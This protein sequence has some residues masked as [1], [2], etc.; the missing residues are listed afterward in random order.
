M[1]K[2]TYIALTIGPIYRT[3]ESA[4]RTRM[5]WG[6]SYMFS[7][8]IRELV[9]ELANNEGISSESF[10][11]PNTD[12]LNLSHAENSK[13]NGA[14]IFPDRFIFQSKE[15]DLLRVSH[16]IDK[17]FKKIARLI[18]K[19]LINAP[20]FGV[21]YKS[22]SNTL[23]NEVFDQL[24]G[25]LQIY[26]LEQEVKEGD[27]IPKNLY[28]HLDTL[29]LYQKHILDIEQNHLFNFLFRVSQY[30]PGTKELSFLSADAFGID[31]KKNF[32]S[33]VEIST[34][35]LRRAKA[36][37][38]DH[39]LEKYL[40]NYSTDMIE[41]EA[42][43]ED[44]DISEDNFLQ[45]LRTDLPDDFR[46]YHKYIAV[47]YADGDGIG[48]VLEK[49]GVTPDGLK[50]FSKKLSSFCMNAASIIHEYGGLPVYLGGE[51]IFAFVPVASKEENSEA[52][53]SLFDLIQDIDNSF[54]Q[55]F[56]D[57][58]IPEKPTLTF[59]IAISYY[60]SPLYE[61]MK[62][63]RKL[64]YEGKKVK[65]KNS[66]A[67]RIEKHSGQ[68]FDSIFQ[69]QKN[70]SYKLCLKLI[71]ESTQSKYE[72]ENRNFIN[73]IT[74][75]LKD[76]LFWALLAV[77]GNDKLRLS[78]FFDNNFNEPIFKSDPI[79]GYLVD[80]QTLVLKVFEEYLEDS[81]RKSLLYF[82][83]RFIDFINSK[84]ER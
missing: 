23:E 37:L 53:Q 54:N 15:G 51:D 32:K 30:T 10:L 9:W 12:A 63:A 8:I 17:L 25:Y 70:E 56:N 80:L 62:V 19:H 43:L 6:A 7:Y 82:T 24:N 26:F 36:E 21:L 35:G 72:K 20:E 39:S 3:L 41:R 44:L 61:T 55:L 47:L 34:A 57:I 74:H 22:C 11:I 1:N 81:E 4:R 27:I 71:N 79:K 69:K 68:Y 42:H 84:D 66:I 5:L 58:D 28:A 29:E 78:A 49:V 18:S 52:I 60:R 40:R 75:K 67:L 83:L 31:T 76:E 45:Q 13:F 50:L 14:G 65:E 38:Y 77:V 64:M 33:I 2:N 16:A 73:S 48:K 46:N 59:G